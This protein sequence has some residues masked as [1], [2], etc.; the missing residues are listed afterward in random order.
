MIL[1]LFQFYFT[2]EYGVLGTA[3]TVTA[4]SQTLK[5]YIWAH[6]V[7]NGDKGCK[8]RLVKQRCAIARLWNRLNRLPDERQTKNVFKWNQAHNFLW[9]KDVSAVFL[10][11]ISLATIYSLR[12]TA[13]QSYFISIKTMDGWDLEET[14]TMLGCVQI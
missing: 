12:Y 2:L 9:S 3:L 7:V 4:S 14:Q 8:S 10:L 5:C 1:R 11:L 6:N 13:K